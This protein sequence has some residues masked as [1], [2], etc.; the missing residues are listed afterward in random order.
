[1]EHL[2]QD[3][4]AQHRRQALLTSGYHALVVVPL[5]VNDEAYGGLTTYY[6]QKRDFDQE[7]LDVAML[8][9]TQ[10][11]LAIQNARLRERSEEIA[12]TAERNRIARDL[13]DSVTQTLFS[14][15][16]IADV[17][18]ILWTMQPDEGERRLTE[19]RELTRGAL[20]E[21]RTLLLELRPATL[22]DVPLPELL[23][24]LIDGISA[25]GM[26][27]IDIQITGE[28][29]QPV[30][31]RVAFFRTAQEAMNNIAKHSQATQATVI[32]RC[33]PTATVIQII[34]NGC[35]FQIDRIT[36]N[37]LGLKI[38]RERAAAI[39]GDLEI[40]S[41]LGEGTTV[42]LSWKARKT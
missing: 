35:G 34:D 28:C 9:G 8:F 3:S 12:V 7:E 21:M 16:M 27:A 31:V 39:N 38:M 19:L 25:R 18:P 23:Q 15:S 4:T 6:Q 30:D 42:Q 13:H 22:E 11:S 14:A 2:G 26:F 41:T 32:L 36:P 29:E 37:H 20:A 1:M 33:Q 40:N 10:I 5:M 17:L 24:Q